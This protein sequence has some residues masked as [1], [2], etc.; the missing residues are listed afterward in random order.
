MASKQEV[1]TTNNAEVKEVA[2]YEASINDV[3]V[4]GVKVKVMEQVNVPTL[5]H[6]TGEVVM[7]R[8]DL[9]IKQ[10]VQYQDKEVIIDGVKRM[11]KVE[12]IINVARVTEFTSKQAFE[13][14]CN[15]I[16]ADTLDSAYPN[17]SYVG[18]W[19]AIKKLGVVAGKRYKE[20]QIVRVEPEG[21]ERP[22]EVLKAEVVG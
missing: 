11:S 12:N 18:Q 8:F 17:N 13:Y 14:V 2:S 1:A 20:V 6:D 9:P 16:T 19:F 4:A 5:K 7:I 15:A 3:T 10:S 21:E 22:I